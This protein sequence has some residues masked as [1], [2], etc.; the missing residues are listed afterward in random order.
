MTGGGLTAQD[1]VFVQHKG[2]ATALTLNPARL[3]DEVSA[4]TTLLASLE[5][6]F[7]PDQAEPSASRGGPLVRTIGAGVRLP[8]D[9]VSSETTE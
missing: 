3:P 7:K 6:V 2:N 8:D 4:V 9:A 5:P 1:Y